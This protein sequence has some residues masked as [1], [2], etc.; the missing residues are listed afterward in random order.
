[1]SAHMAGNKTKTTPQGSSSLVTSMPQAQV[2]RQAD[3][4]GDKG[5]GGYSGVRRGISM[6]RRK[7]ADNRV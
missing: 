7:E 6:V 4:S 2:V 3:T 5:P 1:M